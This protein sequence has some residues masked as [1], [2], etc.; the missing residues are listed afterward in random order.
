M[1][2]T[3][4]KL[5][6]A[7]NALEPDAEQREIAE[8]KVWQF[9][10]ESYKELPFAPAWNSKIFNSQA[11]LPIGPSRS[12][13]DLLGHYNEHL[14]KSG[15]NLRSGRFMAYVSGGGLFSAALAEFIS[16][17]SNIYS[18]LNFVSPGAVHMENQVI[19]WLIKEIGFPDTAL[20]NIR[21]SFRFCE[22][23]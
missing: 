15:G 17:S 22:V 7:S 2:E 8:G 16:S 1:E 14:I 21:N 23:L 13:E 12:L 6:A 20:G 3:I 10:N 18:A 19:D 4:L 5:E 9:L 11:E